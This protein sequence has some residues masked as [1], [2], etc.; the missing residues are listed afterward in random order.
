MLILWVEWLLGT[1]SPLKLSRLV[2]HWLR[3]SST[4]SHAAYIVKQIESSWDSGISTSVNFDKLPYFFVVFV[5]RGINILRIN[6]KHSIIPC[7]IT[8]ISITA[9]RKY[10]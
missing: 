8:R 7:L 4:N 9:K 10:D 6:R 2:E 1:P 3:Q 5:C